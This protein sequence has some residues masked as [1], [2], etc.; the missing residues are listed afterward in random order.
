MNNVTFQK[1]KVP[2][3]QE[4]YMVLVNKKPVNVIKVERYKNGKLYAYIFDGFPHKYLYGAK[5][6]AYNQYFKLA[7]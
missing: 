7:A 1:V 3:L 2:G 5:D 4:H 6:T